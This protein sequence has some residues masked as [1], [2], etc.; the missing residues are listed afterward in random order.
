MAI[1]IRE[2]IGSHANIVEAKTNNKAV[3]LSEGYNVIDPI[4]KDSIMQDIEGI[5]VGPTRN[6]TW[7]TEEA[8]EYSIPSWTKPYQRPLIMHHNEKDGKI[9][10]RVVHV[11]KLTKNTRSGTP[12]LLFTCNV[13]DKE[14]KEQIQDGRLKTVSIG[15]IAHDVRC[16]I[17]GE[18]VELDENGYPECGHMRGNIYDEQVCYWKIYKMEAKELSYVIVPSD[19]YAH[20]IRTYKPSK[21]EL[22]LTESLEMNEGKVKD[23]S[24]KKDNENL[25][26]KEGQVIDETV[27]D[28]EKVATPE[29]GEKAPVKEEPVKEEPKAEPTKEEPKAKDEDGEKKEEPKEKSEVEKLKEE[30]EELKAEKIEMAKQLDEVKKHLADATIKLDKAAKDLNVEV[31]LKESL[32]NELITAKTELREAVEENLNSYRQVLNKPVLAKESLESRSLESIKDSIADLK[33]EMTGLQSV[34]HI[35][36]ANDPTAKKDEKIAE[37][38]ALD[39]N[40]SKTNSNINF[41][42]ELQNVFG[43]FFSPKQY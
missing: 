7:Y 10:G 39:V 18:Q 20:N 4:A 3:N 8:L 29:E 27:K 40:E 14:G 38:K 41:R 37:K 26:V 32:E 36:E 15:V 11:E 6:F 30:I 19:V 9:I 23:M 22:G 12:A 28:G 1:E 21:Q 42:E 13:P 24:I 2:Y 31:E 35:T 34:K 5:H 33:E 25:D 16:S 17:C 43:D